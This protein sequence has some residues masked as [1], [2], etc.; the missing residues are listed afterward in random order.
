MTTKKFELQLRI[1]WSELDL[2]GH[3]NNVSYFKYIQSS[4]LNYWEQL[5]IDATKYPKPLGVMLASCTCK[6]MKP[7]FYP[8][9]IT[10]KVSL[11]FIKN[12]SFGFHH[13]IL[14]SKNE[15]VA[16]AYDVMVMFNF[17]KN[18]KVLIPDELRKLME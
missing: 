2:F 14:N 13:Q 15:I 5:G 17:E 7:L 18:E 1:D 10:L 12:T 4:R 11:D 6:F 9:T 8:D 16:E 3:V